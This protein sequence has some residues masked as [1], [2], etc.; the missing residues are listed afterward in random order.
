MHAVLSIPVGHVLKYDII[1]H[2]KN[3]GSAPKWTPPLNGPS[4]KNNNNNNTQTN[5]LKTKYNKTK[6]R[7]DVQYWLMTTIIFMGLEQGEPDNVRETFS[8]QIFRNVLKKIYRLDPVADRDW[9]GLRELD[10]ISQ[11]EMGTFYP[12]LEYCQYW[13][14]TA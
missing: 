1:I 7:H 9:K 3:P 4:I 8:G 5:K 6:W 12:N 10:N 13:K 2:F 14:I 11:K